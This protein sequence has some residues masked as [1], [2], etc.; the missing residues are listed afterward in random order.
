M[1]S[2]IVIAGLIAVALICATQIIT[3]IISKK[4]DVALKIKS[5]ELKVTLNKQSKALQVLSQATYFK[6]EDISKLR[7]SINKAIGILE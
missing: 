1:T 3:E 4:Y 7:A 5:D 2:M 6:S